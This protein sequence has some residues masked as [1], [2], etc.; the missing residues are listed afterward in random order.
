MSKAAVPNVLQL[1][2]EASCRKLP[3]GRMD[4]SSAVHPP[5]GVSPVTLVRAIPERQHRHVMRLTVEH[6]ISARESIEVAQLRVAQVSHPAERGFD[7]PTSGSVSKQDKQAGGD[8]T[9]QRVG[10]G[11]DRL[12]HG[13]RPEADP[14]ALRRSREL[15]RY[16]ACG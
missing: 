10:A 9:T 11:R 1:H 5:R 14:T 12:T 4:S 16:F 6:D 7:P 3:H 15:R 13:L 2:V 8:G